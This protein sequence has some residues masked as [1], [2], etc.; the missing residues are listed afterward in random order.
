MEAKNKEVI[1]N[2]TLNYDYYSGNDL[3]SEGEADDV[4]LDLV[5]RYSASDYEHVI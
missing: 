2:I 3:Y 1:G 4:L 5:T